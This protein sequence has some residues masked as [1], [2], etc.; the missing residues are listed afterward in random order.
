MYHPTTN[1]SCGSAMKQHQCSAFRSLQQSSKPVV[2]RVLTFNESVRVQPMREKSSEMN[3][4]EKLQAY[5]SKDDMKRFQLEG[6]EICKVAARKAL[7]LSISN[8]SKS[9]SEYFSSIIESD[10][11]LRGLE[12]LACPTRTNNRSMVNKAVLAYNKELENSSL[13]LQQRS[14]ALASLYSSLS[15]CSKMLA[16]LTAKGDMSQAAQAY[17]R[18]TVVTSPVQCMPPNQFDY[19]PNIV[20]PVIDLKRKVEFVACEQRQQKRRKVTL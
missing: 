17:D 6:R 9:P 2:K 3:P 7:A 4:T 20:S 15:C 10:A 18:S 12:C 5:Y 14:S 11:S 13:S 19:T 16:I 8:P 1:K